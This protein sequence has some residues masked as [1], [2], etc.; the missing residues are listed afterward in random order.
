MALRAAPPPGS[1]PPLPRGSTPRPPPPS[2]PR[3]SSPC[4]TA[5]P[6]RSSRP[7]REGLPR[8]PSSAV[9]P[10][11]VPP[12]PAALP[13]SP[14]SRV[15]GAAVA[16]CGAVARGSESSRHRAERESREEQRKWVKVIRLFSLQRGPPYAGRKGRTPVEWTLSE[17]S[18]GRT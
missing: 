4:L 7:R 17:G 18:C 1:L 9:P 6:P 14:C 8:A 5:L 15:R 11:P 16:R 10:G 3:G 12:P 13:L 2:L